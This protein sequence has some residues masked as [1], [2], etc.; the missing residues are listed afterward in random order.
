[1]RPATKL[2]KVGLEEGVLSFSCDSGLEPDL[3]K[4]AKKCRELS[5][6]K[7][8]GFHVDIFGG[9][10]SLKAMAKTTTESAD[11]SQQIRN[12]NAPGGRVPPWLSCAVASLLPFV[13]GGE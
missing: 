9:S 13:H 7:N 12:P 6:L 11:I 3:P 1:M 2:G 8:G 4:N 10:A 5:R